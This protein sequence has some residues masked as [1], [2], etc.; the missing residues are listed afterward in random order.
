M[1]DRFMAESAVQERYGFT[2]SDS[3]EAR[4][5]KVSIEGLLFYVVAFA[6]PYLVPSMWVLCAFFHPSCNQ[7]LTQITIKIVKLLIINH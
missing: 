2:A 1:T 3:F 7:I 4:F 5:S 6:P